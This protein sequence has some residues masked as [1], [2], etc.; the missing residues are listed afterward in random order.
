MNV[1]EAIEKRRAYRS[2]ESV[3][4]TDELIHD[5]AYSAG[6][7]ASCFNNQPWRFIFARSTKV[8]SQLYETVSRSNR[9]VQKASLIV[10]VFSNRESDC[11]INGR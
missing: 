4:I 1:R 7:S 2:L 3:I 10:A 5:L 11:I 8:L 6:L 9:W